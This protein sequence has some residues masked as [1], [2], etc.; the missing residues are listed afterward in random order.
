[1]YTNLK[2]GV[3]CNYCGSQ[4]SLKW[5]SGLPINNHEGE[6][7]KNPKQSG[8]VDHVGPPVLN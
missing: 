8:E 7:C 6:H 1:M 5:P 2:G 3:I 4:R